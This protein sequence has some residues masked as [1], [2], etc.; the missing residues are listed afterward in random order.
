MQTATSTSGVGCGFSYIAVFVMITILAFVTRMP[1]APN[2]MLTPTPNT[3]FLPADHGLPDRIAGYTVLM[4]QTSET[5]ACIPPGV[6][7]LT[8]QATAPDVDSFLASVNPNDV[9][10]ALNRIDPNT[11]W[12]T[13]FVGPGAAR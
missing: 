4:V 8:L 1:S 11:H 2:I 13:E 3:S 10:D 6:V 7:Q 5:T 12:T 9:L